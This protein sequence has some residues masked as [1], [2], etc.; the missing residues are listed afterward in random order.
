MEFKNDEP[1]GRS[2]KI[3]TEP[4]SAS[5][6]EVDLYEEL[7]RFCALSPDEQRK[8]LER[9]ARLP[10]AQP[11]LPAGVDEH[12]K[13]LECVAGLLETPQSAPTAEGH[14]FTGPL[15]G[16]ASSSQ[17]ASSV[18]SPTVEGSQKCENCGAASSPD[19]L[20]CLSCGEL[21]GEMNL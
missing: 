12:P 13:E 19:D 11:S 8:E 2:N 14:V 5:A 21:V 6:A 20:F 15:A 17:L 10:V 4:A 18:V 9:L 16:P 1:R 7:L 3:L